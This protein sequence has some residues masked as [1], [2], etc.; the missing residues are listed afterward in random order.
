MQDDA[1]GGKDDGRR[2][3]AMHE[4]TIPLEEYKKLVEAQ[5]RFEAFAE[6]V[7]S[8]KYSIE[9]EVC[10]GFLGFRLSE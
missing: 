3:R 8:E 2:I 5:V 7:N 9:R 1:A 10:A 6:Y 4:I